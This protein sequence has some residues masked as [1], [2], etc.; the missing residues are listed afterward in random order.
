MI[1]KTWLDE[2]GLEVPTTLDELHDALVAFKE[3]DMA[4]MYG[5][6][7]GSTIPMS[8]GIDQWCWGQNIYY[9]GFGFT[10]WTNDVCMDLLL[11]ARWQGQLR[12]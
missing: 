6:D 12:L 1:N 7:P 4:T 5:N 11:Q 2:L 9:A 3:S 10:N 8:F